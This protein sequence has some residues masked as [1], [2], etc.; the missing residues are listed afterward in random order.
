MQ[1]Q[2]MAKSG[3]DMVESKVGV[4]PLAAVTTGR[5]AQLHRWLWSTI[6][7]DIMPL[8]VFGRVLCNMK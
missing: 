4:T 6:S 7:K 5:G 2:S 8:T 3:Q 1:E